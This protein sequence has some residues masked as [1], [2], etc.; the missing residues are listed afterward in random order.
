LREK[1]KECGGVASLV[2]GAKLNSHSLSNDDV[3]P[4]DVVYHMMVANFTRKLTR[5]QQGTLAEILSLTSSISLEK[6]TYDNDIEVK[7]QQKYQPFV[8]PTNFNFIDSSYIRGRHA[9]SKIFLILPL[10][11]LMANMDTFLCLT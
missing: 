8:L 3:H 9:F 10:K 7:H 11:T 6:N 5:S 2:G 4:R 1:E